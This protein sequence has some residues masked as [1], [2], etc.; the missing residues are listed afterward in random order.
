VV[1]AIKAAD[2]DLVLL[3]AVL[4]G[5][6][7]AGRNARA[8]GLGPEAVPLRRPLCQRGNNGVLPA[9]SVRGPTLSPSTPAVR[10]GRRNPWKALPRVPDARR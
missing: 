8:A 6:L 10:Q 5:R 1:E 3:A 2:S 9:P 7:L 4:A